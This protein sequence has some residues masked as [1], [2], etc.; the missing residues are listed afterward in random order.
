MKEKIELIKSLAWPVIVV[1][2]LIFNWSPIRE[3]VKLFPQLISR[4]E[5]I[6]IAGLS[7]EI[8][9]KLERESTPEI[10]ESLRMISPHLIDIITNIGDSAWESNMLTDQD[11]NELSALG[12]ITRDDYGYQLNEKGLSVRKYILEVVN[13]LIKL[14]EE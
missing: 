1:L 12:L 8:N 4:S 10:K 3:S 11:W 7:I 14:A 6:S 2:F 9:Q 5:S 13:E